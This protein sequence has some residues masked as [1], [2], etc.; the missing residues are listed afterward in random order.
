MDV[1]SLC[2]SGRTTGI[3]LESRGG[4]LHA[5]LICASGRKMGLVKKSTTP[6]DWRSHLAVEIASDLRRK[7]QGVINFLKSSGIVG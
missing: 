3:T 1:L 7:L 4:A 5:V 6:V 2:A